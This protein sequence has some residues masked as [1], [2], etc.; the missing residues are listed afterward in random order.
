MNQTEL[1]SLITRLL[2][3]KS[4]TAKEAIE[5][6]KLNQP[7]IQYIEKPVYYPDWVYKYP[8]VT[9]TNNPVSQTI[10]VDKTEI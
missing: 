6:L 7:K 10:S 9:W 3:T 5:L 2:D 8:I 4:I 1:E